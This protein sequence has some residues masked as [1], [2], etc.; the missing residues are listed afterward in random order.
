M[1]ESRSRELL[2]SIRKII[3]AI[4]IHSRMLNK[5]FGL[6]GPQLIVMQEI[7]SHGQ[8]SITPLSRITSLRQATVTDI[9]QRLEAKGYIS[10]KKNK[11][12]KRATSLFLTDAGKKIID[13][14]PPLL[15]EKFTERFSGMADWEQLMV[16]SAF[17]RVVS[18]MSAEEIDASPVLLTG[19][20]QKEND[21]E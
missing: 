19:P 18:L 14:L 12:D 6:T 4:D 1:D 16:L 3:Q 17:E 7:A 8:I 21:E 20:L 10:R 9:T 15:Q 11:D 13:Q 2:I 5:R